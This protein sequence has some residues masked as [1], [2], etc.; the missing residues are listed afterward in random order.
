MAMETA[1]HR[2]KV[3][4]QNTHGSQ[5]TIPFFQ[6]KIPF[7][8]VGSNILFFYL[9]GLSI[10][11]NISPVLFARIHEKEVHLGISR[12]FN[13]GLKMKQRKIRYSKNRNTFWKVICLTGRFSERFEKGLPDSGAMQVY[14]PGGQFAP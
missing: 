10:G 1:D 11:Y 4:A 3:S 9:S 7:T 13:N 12:Y 2:E 8:A 6:V 5:K 14:F